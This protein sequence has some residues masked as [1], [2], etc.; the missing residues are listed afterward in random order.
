MLVGFMGEIGSGKDTAADYLVAKGYIKI[1]FADSLKKACKEIFSFEDHQLY[2]TQKQ[3]ET[4]D[5]RWENVTPR[6]I[7]Q[8]FGTECMRDVMCK[9]M[10]EMDKGIWVKS[11]EMKLQPDVDYA[12]CDTRFFNEAAMI[13]RRGGIVIKLVRYRDTEASIASHSSETEMS[14]IPFDYLIDNNGTLEELYSA[15]NMAIMDF[16]SRNL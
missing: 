16:K 14:K 2:G 7:I 3:K 5:P 12:V 4:P 9:I 11:L 1:A 6:K 13:K 8:H 15:I 10:P